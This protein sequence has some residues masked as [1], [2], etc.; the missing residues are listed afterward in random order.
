M[1]LFFLFSRDPLT[2]GSRLIE[3]RV[4]IWI[5]QVHQKR[6][7]RKEAPFLV[8]R[9]RREMIRCAQTR[10]R[11][12]V[13]SRALPM[14]TFPMGDGFGFCAFYRNPYFSERMN[15]LPPFFTRHLEIQ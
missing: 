10:K 6:G 7:F 4:R 15:G 9:L 5:G 14:Q 1:T 3:K 13:P 8:P 2:L 11:T 12:P